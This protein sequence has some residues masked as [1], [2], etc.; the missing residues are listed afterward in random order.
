MKRNTKAL[1]PI[2]ATLIILA[3]VTVLFIPVF[4]WVTGTS[5]QTEDFWEKSGAVI[6]ERIVIEEVY[7][8]LGD[9]CTIYVRNIGKTTVSIDNIF[10]TFPDGHL[11]VYDSGFNANPNYATQGELI[12]ISGVPLTVSAG[13]YIVQVFTPN[14]V[15]DT[16]QVV[17]E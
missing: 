11:N 17:V 15:G 6:T 10:I 14:G 8:K 5:S 13:L 9:P 7:M 12:T 16:Y 3:V 1:S 4:I 2:F